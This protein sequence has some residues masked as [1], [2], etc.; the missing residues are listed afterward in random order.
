MINFP[1]YKL[2]C[3]FRQESRLEILRWESNYAINVKKRH[4]TRIC[5]L[6]SEEGDYGKVCQTETLGLLI[7]TNFDFTIILSKY[8]V[9]SKI[10]SFSL[11]YIRGLTYYGLENAAFQIDVN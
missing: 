10:L 8:S 9:S 3:N 5:Q 11:A 6:S 1:Y 7:S 4:N 2:L